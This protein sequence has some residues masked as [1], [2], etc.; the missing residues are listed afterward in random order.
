MSGDSLKVNNNPAVL[1]MTVSYLSQDSSALDITKLTQGS[2][3]IAKVVIKNTGSRGRYT[4]MALSQIFPSGWEILNARMTGGEGAFKSSYST[5]QDVRDDRIY[6]YFD[7][8]Q[9]ETLTYY[10]QLNAS[11]LGRYF[12]PGTFA[13]A[14]Y[15]NSIT[16]G[17]NGKW[18][19]VVNP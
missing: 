7:I 8:N 16:A 11:Y 3:F 9:N 19:E 2:D 17:V 5:Y 14:M 10:V 4:E 6:T 13:A 1:S 12:L 15:D 18:V